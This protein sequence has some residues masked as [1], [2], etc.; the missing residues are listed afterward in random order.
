MILLG[1]FV[2]CC[3][4]LFLLFQNR[5]AKA[6]RKLS[7]S[8]RA[9]SSEIAEQSSRQFLELAKLSFEKYQE[10]ARHELD[11]KRQAIDHLLKPLQETMKQFD[12]HQRELEKRRE[13]AYAA[14]STQLQDLMKAEKDL[15]K[16][17]AQLSQALKSPQM[18]GSWG[19]IHLRRVIEV[20]GLLNHCD[21]FEQK[22]IDSE[23]KIWRP[24]VVVR[25]PLDRCIAID[26]KTPLHAYLDASDAGDDTL[27]QK[28]LQDFASS[29]RKHIKD[30]SAKEYWKQLETSPEYVILF[31]PA[32]VFF[33]AALQ[34]DPTL[35]EV[36][37][38]HNMIIAT[39]TTLIAILRAVAFSWRQ[40]HLSKNAKEVALLG[41]ELYERMG[42]VCEHW[43][44]V[45]RSLTAATDAYNQSVASMESRVL[46]TARKL[47]EHG[48]ITTEITDLQAIEKAV[49]RS[50]DVK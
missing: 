20:A 42:T 25:L 23:G 22:T 12:T 38:N 6:E 30:L 37:A 47:K 4:A 39:P 9:I 48:S 21:F 7:D 2:V 41:R 34:A 35:I 27:R 18:R 46:V 44:R 36:G 50:L 1:L 16:E 29:L 28:K 40:E 17:T 32:E 49:G 11:A 14:L 3:L 24:D 43:N 31:L 33:S 26:A 8:Y 13:G 10:G 5:L 19:E 45:G 15:R